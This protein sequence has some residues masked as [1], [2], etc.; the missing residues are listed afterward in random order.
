MDVT[1]GAGHAEQRACD[2]AASRAKG[3][4]GLISRKDTE[5]DEGGQLNVDD[6]AVI[7]RLEN[8]P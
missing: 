3:G 8:A 1:G 6:T 4:G 7:W 5:V 2:L